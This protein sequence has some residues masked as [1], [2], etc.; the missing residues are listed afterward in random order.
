L[1]PRTHA[2][3]SSDFQLE[4][5]PKWMESDRF[6]VIA[7]AQAIKAGTEWTAAGRCS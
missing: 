5:G 4:G 3:A 6:D 2:A 1:A 7:K